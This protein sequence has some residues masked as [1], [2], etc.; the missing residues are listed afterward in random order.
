MSGWF[1]TPKQKLYAAALSL[2][3]LIFGVLM[4]VSLIGDGT[5]IFKKIYNE[6]V[7]EEEEIAP[8]NVGTFTLDSEK[9]C[10]LEVK[11]LTL[12]QSW[13]WVSTVILDEKDRPVLSYTFNLSYYHGYEGGESWSEGDKDD[14]KLFRLPAGSYKIMV[15]GEDEPSKTSTDPFAINTSA[16][17]SNGYST[18][19]RHEAIQ[20]RVTKGVWM[21]RYFLIMFLLF[22][23]LL[24]IYCYIRSERSK[25][26]AAP[27]YAGY[28]PQTYDSQ[29]YYQQGQ[30]DQ[31]Q[32]ASYYQGYS[33]TPKD[34]QNPNT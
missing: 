17:A 5:E 9:L 8:A 16:F 29:A 26:E 4:T 14:Y 32:S 31:D 1:R 10:M 22:G 27:D 19:D 12:D 28:E 25:Y 30:G 6:T 20:V 2:L 23:T 15:H 7:F 11:G 3:T 24:S 34:P 21:T 18:I 13:L 33:P